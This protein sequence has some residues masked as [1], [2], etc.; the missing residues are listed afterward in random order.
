MPLIKLNDAAER[1]GI[2]RALLDTIIT[3]GKELN[4]QK[5][6]SRY[7]VDEAELDAWIARERSRTFELQREDFLKAF[8]FALKINYGGHTR[9]DF[10]S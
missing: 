6:G 2:K 4:S 10:S 3:N 9:S 8:K 7:F 5:V 1:I